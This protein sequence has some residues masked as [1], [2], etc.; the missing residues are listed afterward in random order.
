M[1]GSIKE[2]AEYARTILISCDFH[3]INAVPLWLRGVVPAGR[4]EL[5]RRLTCPVDLFRFVAPLLHG[6]LITPLEGDR[7]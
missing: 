6:H 1:P 3:G 2:C 5:G 4:L 7:V